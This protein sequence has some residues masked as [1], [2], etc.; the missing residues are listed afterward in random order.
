MKLESVKMLLASCSEKRKR[1]TQSVKKLDLP[2]LDNAVP[3]NG[4]KILVLFAPGMISK[5]SVQP[6]TDLS[7]TEET[8]LGKWWKRPCIIATTSEGRT[9]HF[10][11]RDIILTLADKEG[12]T[13]VDEKLR[14]D[15]RRYIVNADITTFSSTLEIGTVQQSRF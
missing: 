11:R 3:P 13:H 4:G 1:K 9:I 8:L 14:E 12:G 15:Y 5:P 7:N 10:S 6:I 2:I